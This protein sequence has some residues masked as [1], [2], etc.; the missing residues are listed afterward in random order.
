VTGLFFLLFG[1]RRRR[2]GRGRERERAI[3]DRTVGEYEKNRVIHFFASRAA[4]GFLTLV[5]RERHPHL[6]ARLFVRSGGD[7]G[8][9]SARSATGATPTDASAS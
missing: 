4:T 2:A 3:G 1:A 5:K 9:V 7:C 8:R 6:L